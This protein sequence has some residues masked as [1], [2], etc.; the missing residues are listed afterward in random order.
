[1]TKPTE[2]ISEQDDRKLTLQWGYLLAPFICWLLG[3]AVSYGMTTAVQT[4]QDYQ[5]WLRMLLTS[6]YLFIPMIV[7][8]FFCL[9]IA[10]KRYLIILEQSTSQHTFEEKS[11]VTTNVIRGC[12][13]VAGLSVIIIFALQSI[14]PV[15]D[16][17]FVGN[18][19]SLEASILCFSAAYSLACLILMARSYHLYCKLQ[20]E[21]GYASYLR[22]TV[23]WPTLVIYGLALMGGFSSQKL[24]QMELSTPGSIK[25]SAL[26][27]V[28][29]LLLLGSFSG[30]YLYLLNKTKQER[31]FDPSSEDS[32]GISGKHAVIIGI[33]FILCFFLD[34]LE[35]VIALLVCVVMCTF[36]TLYVGRLHQKAGLDLNSSQIKK[37]IALGNV[38]RVLLVFFAMIIVSFAFG[39][40]PE[41]PNDRVEGIK[42]Y[43]II[44]PTLFIVISG[45]ICNGTYRWTSLSQEAQDSTDPQNTILALPLPRKR[46]GWKTMALCSLATF[47]LLVLPFLFS[48][49]RSSFTSLADETDN[50]SLVAA[51]IGCV[52]GIYS[53]SYTKQLKTD[54]DFVIPF[55]GPL[56]KAFENKLD[57][58]RR[59]ESYLEPGPG[60]AS[61]GPSYRKTLRDMF[62]IC[63]IVSLFMGYLFPDYNHYFFRYALIYSAMIIATYLYDF[64]F[65]RKK[66]PGTPKAD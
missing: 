42:H 19:F 40:Y 33:L 58:Y 9:G 50:I 27:L 53:I 64:F 60:A 24:L 21:G 11:R 56:R 65:M 10:R 15:F 46:H 55:L 4:A 51:I 26:L 63:T 45:Y 39:P 43:F 20:K 5:E 59:L 30:Y 23:A 37:S 8:A 49:P 28:L 7:P 44:A 31:G 66:G 17:P 1:M 48:S 34:V 18:P 47:V 29:Y 2:P 36:E 16:V 6:A 25:D 12:G 61:T 13:I 57:S 14:T 54:E 35:C 62:I 3:S 52:S 38:A 22:Y 41:N 32:V